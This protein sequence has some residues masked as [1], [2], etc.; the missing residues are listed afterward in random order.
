MMLERRNNAFGNHKE[1][2]TEKMPKVI[3]RQYNT[4]AYSDTALV[5]GKSSTMHKQTSSFQ[6][7][8]SL[9]Q[10]SNVIRSKSPYKD[11]QIE[12]RFSSKPVKK[13]VV[14]APPEV[15]ADMKTRILRLMEDSKSS[16]DLEEFIKAKKTR[17]TNEIYTPQ[18]GLDKAITMGILDT[19]L[20][21]HVDKAVKTALNIL[22][23]GGSVEDAKAVCEPNV[24][25]QLTRWKK[26][27][28]VFLA[29]FLHGARYT[30]FGRHFTK[31]DKL[32]E[33]E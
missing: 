8:K 18:Y 30:S 20:V 10:P 15:D 21:I 22:E 19:N 2:E 5:K 16:F 23:D 14:S 28:Q 7:N 6:D 26:K 1:N 3:E 12:Q 29:P 31:V 4:V 17:C 32:K 24:L 33:E 9:E 11:M 25:N 27:L 13:A